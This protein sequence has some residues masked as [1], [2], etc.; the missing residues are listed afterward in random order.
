MKNIVTAWLN[1]EREKFGRNQGQAIT[2]L[3]ESLHTHYT[4]QRLS[5]WKTEKRKLPAEVA[6]AMLPGAA[7]YVNGRPECAGLLRLPVPAK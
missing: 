3:N 4:E 1:Y 5:E 6:N 7:T 2:H